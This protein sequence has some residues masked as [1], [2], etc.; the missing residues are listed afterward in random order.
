MTS[1][2][3]ASATTTVILT[4]T[5][6]SAPRASFHRVRPSAS[7]RGRAALALVVAA[8]AVAGLSLAFLTTLLQRTTVAIGAS[9]DGELNA[10]ADDAIQ[11]AV[12]GLWG[13]IERDHRGRTL[14]IEDARAAL[15][16]RG[17]GPDGTEL[18]LTGS[19][20]LA[21]VD[22]Q[23]RLGEV[24]VDRLVAERSDQGSR[25]LVRIQVTTRVG[26]REGDTE[27]LVHRAERIFELERRPWA[28]GSFAVVTEDLGRTAASLAVDSAPRVFNRDPKLAGTFEHVRVAGLGALRAPDR[29]L[30]AGSL[31][32]GGGGLDADGRPIRDWSRLALDTVRLDAR[33]RIV[34][35]VDERSDDGSFATRSRLLLPCDPQQYRAFESLYLDQAD[36]KRRAPI[37]WPTAFPP[38]PEPARTATSGR[39]TAARVRARVVASGARYHFDE[40]VPDL[41][42]PVSASEADRLVIDGHVAGSLVAIGTPSDP[43]RVEGDVV[44]DGDLV[45]GGTVAGR[46]RLLVLGAVHVPID[47]L[48]SDG[49]EPLFG[50]RT[51]GRS[52][53]GVENALA[54][55]AAGAVVLGSPRTP[56]GELRAGLRAAFER[57]QLGD[58]GA[59][60][61][62][63][64]DWT[65]ALDLAL[66]CERLSAQ[67]ARWKPL[68]VDAA[69]YSRTAV[70]GCSDPAAVGQS[71]AITVVGS[72][73]SQNL[74]VDAPSGLRVLFDPRAP[75]LLDLRDPDQVR[76]TRTSAEPGPR[77]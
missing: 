46:G 74:V 59:A 66:L 63:T 64:T 36:P 56:D 77:P 70:V 6:T 16:E 26:E 57:G 38:V 28:G 68:E 75:E 62:P 67:R 34:E 42:A 12:T 23:W 17:L 25:T 18:D 11:L 73:A 45:I 5:R 15:T 43:I 27:P 60:L 7:R 20:G 29:A 41:S 40:S 49:H 1:D 30:V 21:R 52:F 24:C 14:A 47:L 72:L 55:A 32:L 10:A 65:T 35:R 44:I 33:G 61:A 2:A 58:A 50:G 53:A 3:T 31:Y 51:L 71:G 39:L 37:A 9:Y 69:L 54:I 4:S 19:A 13:A 76:L 8:F 22:D 48:Y